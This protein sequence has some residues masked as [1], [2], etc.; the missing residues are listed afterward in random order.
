[1]LFVFKRKLSSETLAQNKPDTEFNVI[2]SETKINY[3]SDFTAYKKVLV[4]SWNKPGLSLWNSIVF[5]SVTS[6]TSNETRASAPSVTKAEINEFLDAF[7]NPMSDDEVPPSSAMLQAPSPTPISVDSSPAFTQPSVP[8]IESTTPLASESTPPVAAPISAVSENTAGT[9]SSE[10][11]RGGRKGRGTQKTSSLVPVTTAK[12][13]TCSHT[14][15][16][17]E[18]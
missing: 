8:A 13:A 5:G 12:R 16:P 15:A 7:D 11:S 17:P 1:M 9:S 3:G 18:K 2:G 14:A 4:G 6:G 10:L